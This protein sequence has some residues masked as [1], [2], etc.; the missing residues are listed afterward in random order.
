MRLASEAVPG[1]L[2]IAILD[3]ADRPGDVMAA[4]R[5]GLTDLVFHGTGEVRAR[6]EAI[7]EAKSAHL[8]APMTADL[9]L[10]R[11][12]DPGEACRAIFAAKLC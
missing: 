4:L 3:C 12:R 8:Y 10:G 2:F 6:L 7:A 9:D 11:M 5:Q 1:A